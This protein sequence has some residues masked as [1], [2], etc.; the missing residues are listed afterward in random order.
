MSSYEYTVKKQNK[1][2]SYECIGIGG[3]GGG[4]GGDILDTEGK[5]RE[6]EKD[7]KGQGKETE[8]GQCE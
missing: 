3:C 6:R 5:C 1:Q 8:G 7:I 4:G 2:S